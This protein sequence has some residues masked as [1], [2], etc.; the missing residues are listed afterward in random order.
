MLKIRSTRFSPPLLLIVGSIIGIIA[1][2]AAQLDVNLQSTSQI[3]QQIRDNC[4]KDN[5]NINYSCLKSYLSR[6]KVNP[7]NTDLLVESL[8]IATIDVQTTCHDLAHIIG[9]SLAE[10]YP[11]LTYQQ[12]KESCG[13]GCEFGCLHGYFVAQIKKSP[14]LFSKLPYVCEQLGDPPYPEENSCYHMI[15]H[16]STELKNYDYTQALSMCDQLKSEHQ[17]ECARGVLMEYFTMLPTEE[18]SFSFTPPQFVTFCQ[19]L[20]HKYAQDA[21]LDDIGRYVTGLVDIEVGNS[22]CLLLDKEKQ[23]TCTKGALGQYTSTHN[24]VEV[25]RHCLDSTDSK[26]CIRQVVEFFTS[27]EYPQEKID[28]FCNRSPN[29]QI[30]QLCTSTP[31]AK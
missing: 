9:Q 3:S 25:W 8:K 15:G 1:L 24:D 27:N 18:F 14:D 10:N 12:A 11:R 31:S 23:V 26:E 13:S 19:D 21:C 6:K 7:E 5:Q 20:E 16:A 30:F 28:Q 17:Y 22:T 2:R 4:I 29:T